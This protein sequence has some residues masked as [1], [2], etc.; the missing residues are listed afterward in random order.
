[1]QLQPNKETIKMIDAKNLI[2]GK[3]YFHLNYFDKDLKLPDIKTLIYIGEN[4]GFDRTCETL[5]LFQN[6]ESYIGSSDVSGSKGVVALQTL[7][8]LRDWEGLISEL[9]ERMVVQKDEK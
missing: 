2:L 3:C 1:M 5:W 6:A 8:A 4:A 9:K 7:S